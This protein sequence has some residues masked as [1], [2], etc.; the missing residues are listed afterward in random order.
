MRTLSDRV[1]QATLSTLPRRPLPV[2]A[3]QAAEELYNAV[4]RYMD[5]VMANNQ[6]RAKAA[7]ERLAL[8]AMRVLVSYELPAAPNYLHNVRVESIPSSV[9]NDIVNARPSQA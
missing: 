8:E 3:H 9:G 5:A 2:S 6:P 4:D 7:A 1:L